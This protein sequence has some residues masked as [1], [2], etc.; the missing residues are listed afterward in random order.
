MSTDS[1]LGVPSATLKIALP[2]VALG[3]VLGLNRRSKRRDTYRTRGP[4][5]SMRSADAQAYPGAT[6]RI[7]WRTRPVAPWAVRLVGDWGGPAGLRAIASAHDAARHRSLALGPS[8][9]PL[10]TIMD[11][12]LTLLCRPGHP[13]EDL[14]VRHIDHFAHGISA[15]KPEVYRRFPKARHA[16]GHLCASPGLCGSWYR[17]NARTGA[18]S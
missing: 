13:S 16:S 14:G 12:G 4:Y 10:L 15:V 7:G 11:D 9:N 1:I 18:Y 6:P 5:G 8:G 3:S 17:A 2:D